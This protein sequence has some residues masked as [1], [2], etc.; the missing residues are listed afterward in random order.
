MER[1]CDGDGDAAVAAVP[2]HVDFYS[3]LLS[4]SVAPL[5]WTQAPG[6]W[7]YCKAIEQIARIP[8]R[9]LVSMVLDMHWPSM[10]P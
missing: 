5:N 7:F 4:S 8:P 9:Q 6:M 2:R 1:V 3:P 10:G